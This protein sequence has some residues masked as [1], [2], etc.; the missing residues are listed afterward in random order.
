MPGVTPRNMNG[1]N[2][3]NGYGRY[4]DRDH[5]P[6]SYVDSYSSPR[7]PPPSSYRGSEFRLEL[8]T[9]RDD[10]F[11]KINNGYEQHSMDSRADPIQGFEVDHLAT[12][13]S[14][15]G[16]MS[17]EDGLRKLKH[18]ENTTGIWTMRCEMV[19]ESRDI[20]IIDKGNGEEQERFTLQTVLEPTAVVDDKNHEVYSNLILFTVKEDPRNKYSPTDMHIFQSTDKMAPTIVDEILAAKEGRRRPNYQGPNGVPPRPQGP[21]PNPPY[22]GSR[23][24]GRNMGKSYF[25]YSPAGRSYPSGGHQYSARGSYVDPPQSHQV[26]N[27]YQSSSKTWVDQDFQNATLPDYGGGSTVANY[28]SSSV[29]QRQGLGQSMNPRA[30][31][32]PNMEDSGQNEVL[33]RDVQL[34]NCCFD[35]IERFVSRLQAAA[36]SYKEL[37]RRKRER[38]AR[39]HKTRGGEGLL[40]MKARPPPAEDFVDIFQKFKYAF[41]LLAK[42][43]AHIHDPN[44]P[45]LVHFLFTPLSLIFEAS[46]D[47]IHGGADLAN[48]AR[49]PLLSPESKQLL[50]NCLTSKEL[51]LWQALG[52]HWT[53]T[54]DEYHGPMEQYNPRFFNGWTPSPPVAPDSRMMMENAVNNMGHQIDQ[55]NKAYNSHGVDDLMMPYPRPDGRSFRPVERPDVEEDLYARSTKP[56]SQPPP[57]AIPNTN[58]AQYQEYVEKHIDR[59]KGI[60]QSSRPSPT[61][62]KPKN[63]Q[64]E[65][66]QFAKDLQSQN[67]IMY[68][69]VHERD[70]RNEK[71][72]TVQKGDIVEVIDSSRNWW[73]VRNYMGEQGY[74]PYT[75]MKEYTPS[76]NFGADRNDFNNRHSGDY[77]ISIAPRHN[78]PVP[79]PMPPDNRMGARRGESLRYFIPDSDDND[80]DGRG[81]RPDRNRDKSD[82]SFGSHNDSNYSSSNEDSIDRDGTWDRHDD[83]RDG[84]RHDDRRDGRRHDDRRD[85]RDERRDERRDDRREERRHEIPQSPVPPPPPTTRPPAIKKSKQPSVKPKPAPKNDLHDELKKRVSTHVIEAPK[86]TTYISKYSEPDEVKDWLL[87]KGF[88]RH[89]INTFDGYNGEELFALQKKE[90]N[91]FLE[92]DEAHKLDSMLLV[93][94][95]ISNYGTRGGS[96][97]RKILEDRKKKAETSTSAHIGSPP[98]FAPESP[99]YSEEDS[100]NI[101]FWRKYKQILKICWTHIEFLNGNGSSYSD[102]FANAG[103]TLRAMLQQRRR[104]IHTATYQQDN[105]IE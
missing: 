24:I 59:N 99:D 64:E 71:E 4:N 40:N 10:D 20:V 30:S 49:F 48:H 98:S 22:G 92:K 73:K 11:G 88:S 94:K 82:R 83:R 46:R 104:K 84:R 53:T 34:L 16:P 45:E 19:V 56:S 9:A 58:V 39:R 32:L 103:K 8:N 87:T 74:A 47:P 15:S 68:E 25:S 101:T 17:V 97:L 23:W 6:S 77:N 78:I 80:Y 91:R 26:A 36:E 93:Q 3:Y 85:R 72:I 27:S 31:Y 66:L 95:K 14:R 89:C 86:G 79:P 41:N 96:E 28:A 5:Y 51:E 90:M 65:N 60:N 35:D 33:E 76:S 102:D 43:K 57:G 81:R 7:R 50:L 62:A 44:A 38:N 12:Y 18:M 52:Q 67:K 61:P 42:L 105:R 75:I 29:S 100:D 70:G 2:D 1:Y 55:R 13:T 54:K 69:I 21:A 63:R 37:E